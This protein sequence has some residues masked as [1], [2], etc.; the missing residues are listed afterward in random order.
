MGSSFQS[1]IV[2]CNPLSDGRVAATPRG[3]HVVLSSRVPWACGPPKW[4]KSESPLRR[5]AGLQA[6]CPGGVH[7]G[8][9]LVRGPGGPRDSRSGDRRYVFRGWRMGRLRSAQN[10]VK[11][12][13]RAV[14]P[15]SPAG[16]IGTHK[17]PAGGGAGAT[18][19]PLREARDIPPMLLRAHEKAGPSPSLRSGS[20]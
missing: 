13:R 1:G 12:G 18:A 2:P 4:M 10:R 19:L 8:S 17:G 5:S 3:P 9:R 6:G 11:T 16:S 14:L 15:Y 7:S 20:G